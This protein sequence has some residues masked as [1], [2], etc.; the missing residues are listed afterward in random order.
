MD[1]K[2]KKIYVTIFFVFLLTVFSFPETV[3]ANF[4][5]GGDYYYNSGSA[6]YK[7]IGGSGAAY[8][9]G[10]GYLSTYGYLCAGNDAYYG[11][12]SIVYKSRSG[13]SSYH[14]V[15]S[16]N[17]NEYGGFVCGNDAY[18]GTRN[19]I[20]KSTN[21]STT[22]YYLLG[23]SL[24][25]D[26]SFCA[27]SDAYYS[28]GSSVY[29]SRSGNTSSHYVGPGD[30]ADEG[31]FVCGNDAY[32]SNGSSVYKSTN[33]STSGYYVGP[34]G[35]VDH[36]HACVVNLD[37]YFSNGSNVYKSVQGGTSGFR[38]GSGDLLEDGNYSCVNDLYFG[39]GFNVYKSTLNSTSGSLLHNGNLNNYGASCMCNTR[40]FYFSDGNSVYKTS[41]GSLYESRVGSGLVDDRYQSGA[42]SYNSPDYC[43]NIAGHQEEVPANHQRQGNNCYEDMCYN[44]SGHQNEVPSGYVKNGNNC[45]IDYCSNIDGYQSEVPDGYESD[46]GMCYLVGNGCSTTHFSSDYLM[47]KTVCD[48]S[49]QKEEIAIPSGANSVEVKVWGAGGSS[50]KYYHEGSDTNNGGVGAYSEAIFEIGNEGISEDNDLI[51]L[52]GH[53]SRAYEE[54]GK[55][56]GVF[57][58]ESKVLSSCQTD[59]CGSSCQWGYRS[60]N[61]GNPISGEPLAS[62]DSTNYQCS[63]YTNNGWQYYDSWFN[64]WSTGT[65]G[66][67]NAGNDWCKPTYCSQV[68]E[69]VDNRLF[70]RYLDLLS[71]L[72][73]LFVKN[74][75]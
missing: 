14:Y 64:C 61:D 46:D 31:G 25:D 19:Q 43:Q 13:N 4:Y 67:T 1:F 5:C 63:Y 2:N 15:G 33:N 8:Y 20:Y 24:V 9:I 54:G 44:V 37:G 35:I 49:G 65:C 60:G 52:V 27:G 70:I 72:A 16:G 26:G 75:Q 55:L 71:F 22:G 66:N 45:Y 57:S 41:E 21:N 39:D 3:S 62:G 34:G 18:F 51:V 17:I 47:A 59:A 53:G 38:V 29:K 56:T 68:N 10:S 73:D 69:E 74:T 7:K 42:C 48:Y 23:G 50:A 28:N 12:G 30:I 40:E 36:G 32:Y 6:V 58:G 11:N